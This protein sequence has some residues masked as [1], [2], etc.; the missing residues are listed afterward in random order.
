M[1]EG[2]GIKN[3]D[4]YSDFDGYNQVDEQGEYID[5]PAEDDYAD[6]MDYDGSEE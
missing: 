5:E 2:E 3:N 1:I 4:E 6:D